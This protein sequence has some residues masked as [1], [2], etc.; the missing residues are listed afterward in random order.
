ML[1]ELVLIFVGI[2]SMNIEFY[3]FNHS[4]DGS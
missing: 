4:I 1:Q 3:W 2:I